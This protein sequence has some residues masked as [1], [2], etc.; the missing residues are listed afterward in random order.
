[1]IIVKI[2]KRTNEY[3]WE[4]TPSL[5]IGESQ[6]H[7]S[8]G[9]L[10][11]ASGNQRG[12]ERLLHRSLGIVLD[13]RQL[14][15]PGKGLQPAREHR[16]C[17]SSTCKTTDVLLACQS[18]QKLQGH[19]ALRPSPQASQKAKH[20]FVS[21]FHAARTAPGTQHDKRAGLRAQTVRA[22]GPWPHTQPSESSA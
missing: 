9:A 6:R 19:R 4:L 21:S 8:S 16:D 14:P 15:Q 7:T 17:Q 10:L 5:T 12:R 20:V 22:S 18:Q 13:M 3:C 2:I 11:R 1:M